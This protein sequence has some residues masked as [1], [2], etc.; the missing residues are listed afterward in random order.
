M[1]K[2]KIAMAVIDD[3]FSKAALILHSVFYLARIFDFQRQSQLWIV[4]RT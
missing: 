1:S 2:L 4:S 3:H